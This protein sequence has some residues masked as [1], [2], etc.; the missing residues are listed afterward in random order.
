MI[1]NLSDVSPVEV[2]VS[3]GEVDERDDCDEDQ[4]PRVLALA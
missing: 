1:E 2:E 4:Q 3:V